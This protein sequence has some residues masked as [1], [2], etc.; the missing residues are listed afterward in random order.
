[1]SEPTHSV[2][3][4]AYNAAGTIVPAIRSVLAQTVDDFE[5]VVVDD[6]SRDA[7]PELLSDLAAED[8]RVRSSRQDN[9]GPSAARNAALER[10]RGAYLT[11]LD[12]D[13]LLAPGYLE[14]VGRALDGDP[15]VGLVYTRAWVL[16]EAEG[17]RIRRGTYPAGWQVRFRGKPPADGEETLLAL[18]AENFVGAVQTVRAAA[19]ERTGGYDDSLHQ[20]EDYDLWLRI[21]IAGYRFVETDEVLALV[22]SRSGSLSKATVDLNRGARVVCERLIEDYDVS[23]AVR[24]VA[25][26]QLEERDRTIAT[27]TGADRRRAAVLRVRLA[28]GRV[29]R[30]AFAS[31]HWY[32]EPPAEVT[33]TFPELQLRTRT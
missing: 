17:G 9:A 12:S 13:D 14:A 1:V 2:V 20:A 6:G 7:T 8:E 29:Y 18:A 16:D 32:P 11:I 25:Q 21:A 19:I 27:M 5:V 31:R 33:A 10:A 23:D 24:A 3:I 4:A 15:K 28:L 26:A 22:R 30:R